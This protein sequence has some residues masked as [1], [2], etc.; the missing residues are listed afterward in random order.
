MIKTPIVKISSPKRISGCFSLRVIQLFM[1]VICTCTI[2]IYPV[3][4]VKGKSLGSRILG[5]P[6]IGMEHNTHT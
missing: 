6:Y 2:C 1:C 5:V 4:K 3:P